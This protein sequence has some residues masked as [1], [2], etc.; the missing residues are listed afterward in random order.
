MLKYPLKLQASSDNLFEIQ[1]K[2]IFTFKANKISLT[3]IKGVK[4]TTILWATE[5]SILWQYYLSSYVSK[6]YT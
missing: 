4:N 1:I 6:S 3:E 2:I 5:E